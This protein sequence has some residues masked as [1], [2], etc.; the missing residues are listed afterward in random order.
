MT[1]MGI[2]ETARKNHDELFPAHV[3]TLPFKIGFDLTEHL[4]VAADVPRW[5]ADVPLVP[6]APRR[7][8]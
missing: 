7:F 2:S 6:A 5:Q 1:A 4:P 8:A 3:S